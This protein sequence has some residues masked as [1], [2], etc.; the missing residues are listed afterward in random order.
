MDIRQFIDKMNELYRA[1]QP[2]KPFTG[3]RMPI[4]APASAAAGMRALALCR[5]INRG[6]IHACFVCEPAARQARAADVGAGRSAHSAGASGD[7]CADAGVAGAQQMLA[8]AGGNACGV[9][10]MEALMQGRVM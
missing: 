2:N 1:V 8:A 5:N 10:V 7:L 6:C 9:E 3:A 4:V